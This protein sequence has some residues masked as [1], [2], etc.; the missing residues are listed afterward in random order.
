MLPLMVLY[1]K[2]IPKNLEATCFALL[3]GSSNISLDTAHG[4]GALINKLYV[5][6]TK[7]NLENFWVL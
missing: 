5:G 3:T 4:L 1:A 2:I 6:V 7:Q